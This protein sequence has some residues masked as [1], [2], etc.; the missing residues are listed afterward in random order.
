[1]SDK[2]QDTGDLRTFGTGATRDTAQDKLDFEASLSP[3]VLL[4][5]VQYM[6]KNKQQS[7]GSMRE[8]DNWQKGIPKDQ[9]IK[10]LARHMM[11]LRLLHRNVYG[12]TSTD[13][14]EILCALIFNSMGYLF[15]VMMEKSSAPRPEEDKEDV[16]RRLLEQNRKHPRT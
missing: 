9:Y 10:S 12:G 1:M 5:Y 3:M 4:R 14:E 8:G 16:M 2:G 13:V 11:D 15:E 7:D 6:D